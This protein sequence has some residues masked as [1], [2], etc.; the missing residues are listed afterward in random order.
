MPVNRLSM[1]M[2]LA[3]SYVTVEG[4]NTKRHKMN[5]RE[6]KAKLVLKEKGIVSPWLL[7][8]QDAP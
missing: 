6:L 7:V 1:G 8:Q 2:F 4:K 5:C 3:E